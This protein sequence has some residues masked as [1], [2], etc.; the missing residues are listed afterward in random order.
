MDSGSLVVFFLI[1]HI[2]HYT[3]IQFS[4]V[5]QSCLTLCDSLD[6]NTPGLPDHHQLLEFEDSNSCPLSRWCHPTTSSS[7]V[8][9][10]SRLQS[11]PASGSF[12]MSQ[13]FPSGG[14]NIGGSASTPVLPMNTKVRAETPGPTWVCT[15]PGS[16]YSVYR[17]SQ[18]HAESGYIQLEV[19]YF[20]ALWL[21]LR[22]LP[23]RSEF[24]FCCCY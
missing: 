15:F 5:A 20:S 19:T 14:Q 22:S 24:V 8:P 4:S 18:L 2:D 3:I 17:H 23:K 7:V 12:Q 16:S 11:F 9:F 13:L 1:L 10:S 6:C 21:V